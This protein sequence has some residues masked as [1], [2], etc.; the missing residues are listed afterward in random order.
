MYRQVVQ[1]LPAAR[2]RWW[3]P[4]PLALWLLLW[5]PLPAPA[6]PVPAALADPPPRLV[7][8]SPFSAPITSPAGD[9]FLDLL[10]GELFARL[11][12]DFEIQLLPGERALRNA[13]D[14][15]DDGDVCR[16]ANLSQRYPNLVRTTEPVLEYRMAVFSAGE[17]LAL[18]GA[19]SLWPY[20]LGILSGWK[21]LEDV[22]S[23]HPRRWELAATDQLFL[24]LAA[25]RL[26]LVFIDRL[27]GREAIAR[28]EL[29]GIRELS[30]PLLTG[31][32][33]LYLHR[34]HQAL[35]PAIDRELRRMKE[36]GSYLRLRRQGLG[37]FD[38]P[39]ALPPALGVP[40]A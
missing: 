39:G 18:S 36:D 9:G 14:G 40:G 26:D 30:P 19:D 23:G 37:E 21:I 2:R 28:L 22:T 1:R 10:Y 38:D 17:E 5:L 11:G 4:L 32:W 12:I 31:T 33:Y 13:D 3:L 16:I 7:L 8:N 29:T 25:G 6:D 34:R 35:L 24:M 27:L 20:R 15:I